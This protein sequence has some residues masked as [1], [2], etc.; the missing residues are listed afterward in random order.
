MGDLGRIDAQK[1]FINCVYNTLQSTADYD[2]LIKASLSI[3]RR[4][5]TDFSFTDFLIM[6][7]K[8]SSKFRNVEIS[9]VTMPGESVKDTSGIWYYVLNRKAGLE[10]AEKFLFAK[11]DVFDPHRSFSNPQNEEFERI[12]NT[13]LIKY[14]KYTSGDIAEI[15]IAKKN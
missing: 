2:N 11:G 10:V 12:Y 15:D 4:A 1:I 6:M 14:K 3:S 13:N 8:H 5:I 9:Y 7:L